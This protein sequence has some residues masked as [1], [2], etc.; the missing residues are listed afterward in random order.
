MLLLR[1]MVCVGRTYCEVSA[2]Q[3]AS[4]AS[5]PEPLKRVVTWHY[6]SPQKLDIVWSIAE[7]F[8]LLEFGQP[9]LP[10]RLTGCD[11]R[12]SFPAARPMS[13]ELTALSSSDSWLY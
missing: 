9:N 2:S 11:R 3:L 10:L 7:A 12:H 1:C 13:L 5:F 4:C 6:E 8:E